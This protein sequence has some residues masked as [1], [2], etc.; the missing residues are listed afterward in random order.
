MKTFFV[1]SPMLSL[2]MW[3]YVACIRSPELSFS[4]RNGLHS[5]LIS[6]LLRQLI[7]FLYFQTLCFLP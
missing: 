7:F 1:V 3:I 6:F 5:S 4:L 2:G